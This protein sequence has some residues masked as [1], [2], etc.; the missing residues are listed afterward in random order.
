MRPFVR[1]VSG[2]DFLRPEPR[3]S[4]NAPA[5]ST[6]KPPPAPATIF[7]RSFTAATPTVASV[8]VLEPTDTSLSFVVAM[9]LTASPVV[10]AA[11]EAVAFAEVPPF[12][13]AVF[14]LSA[15]AVPFSTPCP[16]AFF[17][18]SAMSLRVTAE[19]EL[20]PATVRDPIRVPQVADGGGMRPTGKG[21]ATGPYRSVRGRG[22][23]EQWSVGT[24]RA[25]AQRAART[26][27]VW[28]PRWLRWLPPLLIAVAL[29]LDATLPPTFTFGS[30]LAASV[31]LSAL[32]YPVTGVVATGAVGIA[33]LVTLHAAEGALY[34]RIIG[35]IV[36]LAV[37]AIFAALLSAARVQALQ[38]LSRVQ[39]VAEVVQL[40]LLRPLPTRIGPLRLA[41]CYR[42]ADNDALIGGD[43]YSVRPTRFGTRVIVGDVKGKGIGATETVTT[44]IS[45]FREAAVS[46]PG[47][48]EIAER[49]ES[50]LALDRADA[51]TGASRAD[52]SQEPEELFATAVLL[53]FSPDAATVRVLNRGHPPL[54]RLGPRGAA[55]L[56]TENGVP[57]GFG[58]L[59][60][61]HSRVS[62][63]A[64]DPDE[65][66]LAYSDGI[67]EARDRHG[68]FYPL[69]DRLT[70]RFGSSPTRNDPAEVI[71]FLQADVAKWATALNDDMVAVALQPDPSGDTTAPP[72]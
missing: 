69:A 60:P 33:A 16:F 57:L 14:T 51:T 15:L 62:H 19:R 66:L 9:E 36:T 56:E 34:A 67:I 4:A 1:R 23:G 7:L 6:T 28:P 26:A 27:Q 50:A 64:L 31:V 24:G 55:P 63:F 18:G 39:T 40:A 58:E 48:A 12:E 8:A 25:A 65:L 54:L 3:P 44:V 53:E 46:C 59:E 61:G 37:V 71:S 35:T 20:K 11:S 52:Q 47:L 68:D 42:G 13:P 41:G 5:S 49:I 70:T 30:L 72:G 10:A 2:P 22:R 29:T 17:T 38:R 21:D 43:L 45:A 32:V